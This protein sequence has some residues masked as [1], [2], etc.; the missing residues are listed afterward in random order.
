M[1]RTGSG[2]IV[3][4]LLALASSAEEVAF[5]VTALPLG[6]DHKRE[7]TDVGVKTFV[8]RLDGRDGFDAAEQA[9]AR[10]TLWDACP[11]G[12]K[13]DRWVSLVPAC[14]GARTDWLAFAF[15]EAGRPLLA[16]RRPAREW[17]TA[18]IYPEN[19]PPGDKQIDRN[20]GIE[21]AA[22]FGTAWA[23]QA[24]RP[25]RPDVALSVAV[26]ASGGDQALPLMPAELEGVRALATAAALQA[27][28]RPGAGAPAAAWTLQVGK[29]PSGYHLTLEMKEGAGE[30]RRLVKRAAQD[31]LY[32]YLV[33][34]IRA[35]TGWSDVVSDFILTDP[36]ATGLL[37]W[38]EDTLYLNG[39]GVM[40][41]FPAASGLK[42]WTTPVEERG[43]PA[44][45]W[46]PWSST[47]GGPYRYHPSI[48]RVSREG[49]V[50][51]GPSGA[52]ALPWGFDF[53]A[54]G[55]LVVA[56]ELTLSAVDARKHT[57]RWSWT[58]SDE[59]RGGPVVAGDRVLVGGLA[60]E[61]AALAL[62]DGRLLWRTTVAERLSGPLVRMGGLVA[63][64]SVEGRLTA[65]RIDTGAIAWRAELGDT[66]IGRS[67]L[68]PAG[69]VAGT[70][71]GRVVLVDPSTG[72]IRASWEGGSPAA[73]CAASGGA[74]FWAGRSG[75]AVVLGLPGLKPASD[76]NLGT[77]LAEGALVAAEAPLVW[78]S[79]E[80]F[81][82]RGPV[83]L[84]ADEE[85][86]VYVLPLP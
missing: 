57:I 55:G 37:G 80:E 40:S 62:A 19:I 61:M 43:Q 12:V 32:P 4:G 60:G 42:A 3:A 47:N 71:S 63:A 52:D 73:G 35:M 17:D 14:F 27:G 11:Q 77:R 50:G 29:A 85:G 45:T 23:A 65:F 76:V 39:A 5:T 51:R 78:G 10:S 54:D 82:K 9:P 38:Q 31:A 15:D 20:A 46:G 34:M 26:D 30:P 44:F 70:R 7:T 16:V 72:A 75:R 8:S 86:F 2:L 24:A 81:G 18:G 28:Y 74:V 41:A 66:V 6:P 68:L 1:T 67:A 22:D 48:V 59:L 58:G 13:A 83:A 36:G 25:S 49:E 56:Q 21:L 33:R 84:A 64:P 69:L 53:T 79:G